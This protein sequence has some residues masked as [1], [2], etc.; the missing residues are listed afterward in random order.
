MGD[1]DQWW[2]ECSDARKPHIHCPWGGLHLHIVNP[3]T[4]MEVS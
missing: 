1:G 4:G 3:E 2:C